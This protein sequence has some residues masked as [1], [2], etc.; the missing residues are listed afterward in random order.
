MR[1]KLLSVILSLS[2]FLLSS[3]GDKNTA[4]TEAS[5]TS[6]PETLQSSATTTQIEET[7]QDAK[8]DFVVNNDSY[9]ALYYIDYTQDYKFDEFI[10]DGGAASTQEL[11]QYAYKA[12]P[13]IKLDLSALGYG[14]SS[15]CTQSTD[16]NIIF[17]R[18]FD[19]DTAN[20]SSYLIVHTAPENGYESYS[21]VSLK[22]LGITTPKEPK[23]D[24]SPLLL[25]PYIPLDGINSQGL[26][27]CVLQLGSPEI[28]TSDSSVDMTSTT[29]IRNVLD[30]AKNVSEAIE[31]F[32]SCNLHTDGFAYHYMVGDSEGNSAIIEF[33]DNEMLVEYKTENIQVCANTYVTDEGISFY[34]DANA[35]DSLNRMNAILN[36]VQANGFDLPTEN[37]FAALKAASSSYTRW[38]IV[39]NLTDKT[40]DIAINQ[41]FGKTYSFSFNK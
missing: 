32:K 3:C 14:C 27:I 26:A 30:N 40:M 39:Y 18:N 5:G 7:K 41:K 38:S 8:A 10:E 21:T 24:T 17:G 34:N 6:S 20:S 36:S 35:A 12:F 23:D 33:V 2:I 11:V 29:I 15:F 25:A 19:M 22:F 28:H 4:Q 1:K 37:A 31:I 9:R 16:G 13:N